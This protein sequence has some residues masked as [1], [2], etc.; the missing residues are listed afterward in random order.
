MAGCKNQFIM[1]L[2][3]I[4]NLWLLCTYL[5]IYLCYSIFEGD[6]QHPILPSGELLLSRGVK[7][8]SRLPLDKAVCC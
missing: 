6:I 7:G 8:I 4:L 5:F 1:K 2:L 3:Q